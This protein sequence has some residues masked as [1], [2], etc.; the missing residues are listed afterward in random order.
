MTDHSRIDGQDGEGVAEIVNRFF[1]FFFTFIIIVIYS[2][3]SV[4]FLF[5]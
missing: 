3:L 4:A 5:S 2:L 1:S